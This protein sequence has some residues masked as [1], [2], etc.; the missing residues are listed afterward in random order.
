LL[1][2]PGSL[3]KTRRAWSLAAT[4]CVIAFY[5]WRWQDARQFTTVTVLPLSG[6]SAVYSD[7]AGRRDDVLIDCGN[8]NAVVFVLKP[9]LHGQGVNRLTCLALTLGDVR[10]VGG[11]G[12]LEGI[13]PI[14]RI[15]TS[16]ARFRSPAYRLVL[17]QLEEQ[18]QRWRAVRPGDA[19]AH[20]T[21]LHP[22]PTNRFSH[23]DDNALVLRGEFGAT[24]MLLL[25]DLGR[26]GQNAL[27]DAG[28]D[29]RADIVVSGLPDQ[30]EPLCDGLLD[31]VQP[32]L[33]VV[34]DSEFPA[35]K[36]AATALRER[37]ERRS[38]PVIFMRRAGAVTITLRRSRWTARAMDGRQFQ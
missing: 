37:L 23:G 11:V 8:T 29:L 5:V 18:P 20:W 25:S 10:H 34:T 26:Q 1:C 30:G 36:R 14:E 15:A 2:C 28:H 17:E 12:A 3:A 35:T 22:G 32:K 19:L 21:V 13:V 16:T 4:V 7:S 27:L 6:G 9:F 31:A 24:R 33:I 38:V